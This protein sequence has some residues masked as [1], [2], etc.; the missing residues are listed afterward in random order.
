MFWDGH[1]GLESQKMT[2]RD[3]KGGY[4]LGPLPSQL[5]SLGECGKLPSGVWGGAPAAN[6]RWA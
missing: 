4:I 5:R 1:I 3:A 2:K 6:D